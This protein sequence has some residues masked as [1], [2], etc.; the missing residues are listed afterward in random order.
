MIM[1]MTGVVYDRKDGSSK[2]EA[3]LI[4]E[5]VYKVSPNLVGLDAEGNPHSI[6][7]T[8]IGVYLIEAVKLLKQ[9]IDAIKNRI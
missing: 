2:N 3:G 6:Q 4:A 5:D 8:K 1:Q 7:Y 9:E